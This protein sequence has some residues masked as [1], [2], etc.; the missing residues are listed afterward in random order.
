MSN[1]DF[2]D[3]FFAEFRMGLRG[4]DR[5][6]LDN[7]IGHLIEL[8]KVIPPQKT[9]YSFREVLVLTALS[10]EERLDRLERRRE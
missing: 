4:E 6:H 10:L 7:L 9:Y 2:F 8:S 5:Q 3:R 1:K